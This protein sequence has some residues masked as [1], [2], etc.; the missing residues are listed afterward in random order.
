MKYY[1]SSLG[2]LASALD[3]IEKMHLEKLN[4]QFLNQQDY[5]S[6]I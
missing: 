2:N 4:V 5:F 6:E 3:E 1:L